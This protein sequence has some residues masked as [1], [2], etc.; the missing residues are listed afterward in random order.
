VLVVQLEGPPYRW[1]LDHTGFGRGRQGR[2]QCD[3]PA[4]LSAGDDPSRAGTLNFYSFT[5]GG[6]VTG[7]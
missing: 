4:G 7:S 6:F 2:A 1:P 5:R 3:G